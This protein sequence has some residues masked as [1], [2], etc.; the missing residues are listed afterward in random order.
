MR[1][2]RWNPVYLCFRAPVTLEHGL[3]HMDGLYIDP[4]GDPSAQSIRA[5]DDICE[6]F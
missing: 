1:A 2:D 4:G 5:V 3:W 6:L